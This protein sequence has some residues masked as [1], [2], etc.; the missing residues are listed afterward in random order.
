[1]DLTTIEKKIKGFLLKY[2]EREHHVTYLKKIFDSNSVYSKSS[3]NI[4]KIAEL[5]TRDHFTLDK[6]KVLNKNP[7][8]NLNYFEEINTLDKA[9]WLGFIY[10]DGNISRNLDYFDFKLGIKDKESV[11]KLAKDIGLESDRVKVKSDKIGRKLVKLRIYSIKLVRDLLKFGVV[12][13]KSKIIRFPEL[14]NRKLDLV[15][16]LGFFDGDGTQGTSVITSSNLK[17]LTQIQQKMELKTH[18]KPKNPRGYY[19]TLGAVLFN[20]MLENYPFSMKR[21]AVRF[22]SNKERT[23][24][25]KSNVWNHHHDKKL[26]ISKEELEKMVWIKPMTKLGELYNVSDK[27]IK[28]WCEKWNINGPKRGDWRKIQALGIQPQ[29]K[30]DWEIIK[31]N[32]KKEDFNWKIYK[33]E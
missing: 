15:F 28:K 1:M 7:N 20:E 24:N 5:L 10:A 33:K 8:F 3:G 21:K 25:I 23:I 31:N 22:K 29:S 6:M 19:L 2:P 17:F 11:L 9:Y 26:N 32:L 18:P 16:L 12:P 27:T 13:N 14:K 4:C 30:K